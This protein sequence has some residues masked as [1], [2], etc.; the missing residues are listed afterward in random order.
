MKKDEEMRR[1]KQKAFE[2]EE[3]RIQEEKLK[4]KNALRQI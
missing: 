1:Q 2:A 4:K 3:K